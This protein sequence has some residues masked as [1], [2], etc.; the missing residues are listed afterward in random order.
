MSSTYSDSIS[1]HSMQFC[2]SVQRL[3]GVPLWYI[4]YNL[5]NFKPFHPNIF[6][7]ILI[8]GKITACFFAMHYQVEHEGKLSYLT[9]KKDRNWI[10]KKYGLR[11]ED[12]FTNGALSLAL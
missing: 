6:F 2:L 10:T 9:G 12:T 8:K 5:Y 3:S 11:Q 4:Q 1:L 7:L